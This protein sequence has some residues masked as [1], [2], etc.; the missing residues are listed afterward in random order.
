MIRRSSESV[1]EIDAD[2]RKFAEDRRGKPELRSEEILRALMGQDH[3]QAVRNF[4]ANS[5]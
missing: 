3:L 2:V 5:A 1:I 4:V